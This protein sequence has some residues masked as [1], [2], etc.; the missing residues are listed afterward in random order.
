MK[1]DGGSYRQS[2]AK[3]A[4]RGAGSLPQA[5][6]DDAINAIV[7]TT[8]S[9]EICAFNRAAE[10]LTGYR[11]D[12]VVGQAKLS[13]FLDSASL[14]DHAMELSAGQ[15]VAIEPGFDVIALRV[16]RGELFEREWPLLQK[17]GGQVPVLLSVSRIALA[18]DAS[19]TYLAILVDVSAR[20]QESLRLQRNMFKGAMEAMPGI[21]YLLDSEGGLLAWNHNLEIFSGL[22]A[23]QLQASNLLDIVFADDRTLARQRA[24]SV[25]RQGKMASIEL[26]MIGRSGR[27]M[28]VL[29]NGSR[30]MVDGKSCVVGAAI[31]LSARKIAEKELAR[32]KHKLIERNESLR[33]I[34]QLSSR[35]HNNLEVD[36]VVQSTLEA[37][38]GY[39]RV[40]VFGI[41]LFDKT[42]RHLRLVASR[43]F[44]E[45]MTRDGGVLPMTGSLS[46]I[47][48]AQ[49]NL[50]VSADVSVD[51]R[52]EPRVR[53]ML[54]ARD[55]G[56]AVVIPLLN[57]GKPLGSI[58]LLYERR[59]DLG[60]VELETFEAIGKAVSLALAN[61][62]HLDSLQYQAHHD[63]LT[64]LPNRIVLHEHF[65]RLAEAADAH[66]MP[67]AMMLLD[68]NHFK[69]IIVTLG[70]HVGDVFL[71]SISQRLQE[72][73]STQ[74]A[75]L[76][77]MGGDEF[78]VL[79]ETA[80]TAR[81][82]A[83]AMLA[84]LRQPF[85][86]EAVH[87]T[88]GG[89][90]GI[91][92]YPRDGA[93]SIAML[94]AADVA[95]YEAKRQGG[96]IRLYERALDRHT[97]ER[98]SLMAEVDAA[99]AS[100]QLCL[101]YQPKV[102]ADSGRVLGFEALVRWQHPRLGLLLPETFIPLVEVSEAIH[103]LTRQVLRL[104]LEEQ[105]RWREHGLDYSVAVNLSA[106][107]LMDERCLHDLQ[108]LMQACGS[109]PSKVELEITETVLMHD[110]AGAIVLL[111][112]I[113]ALGVRL[114]IDDFGTGHSSLAYLRRL[115]IQTLKIDQVFIRNLVESP[116]DAII[117]RSTIGLA[118]QLGLQVIAEGVENAETAA[119]LREMGCDLMQGYHFCHPKPWCEIE[120][121]L[122][123]NGSCCS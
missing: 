39:T 65:G 112:R 4:Q 28:P 71:R 13:D 68:L 62:H 47:A 107:N 59:P 12:E 81:A 61:A 30:V 67:M 35:L 45:T 31:D 104:A 66:E 56:A 123:E 55:I 73:L 100:G 110:P 119:L 85:A 117:V 72:L 10:R 54:Q 57:A 42:R 105:Q 18:D 109:D 103:A 83:E 44:D 92:I 75:L 90:I 120:R 3:P 38:K 63:A 64:G 9:G 20:K 21:F 69:E 11:V 33:V 51:G 60:E 114:S 102:A 94:R 34:N 8:Q 46:G 86:V 49:G 50:V 84:A 1:K 70:H 52:L 113:A 95:M 53:Q 58:N 40:N 23:D 19:S 93:D 118:H 14:L 111:D 17:G 122:E 41:F 43:G 79:V 29:A 106:R 99:I 96:G 89:S 108:Q 22:S 26:R 77:H 37:L 91:A 25:L 48:L 121:W 80:A 87:L 6:F 15:E 82:L 16:E 5:V 97:P 7:L 74:G 76:C 78:V 88:V 116:Q 98:L 32:S 101:H 2:L 24:R 115:P 36:G 27:I